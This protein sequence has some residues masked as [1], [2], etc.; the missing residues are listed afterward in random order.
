LTGPRGLNGTSGSSGSSGQDGTSGVDG[1]NGTS[2]V[3]GRKGE[4]GDKGDRG[5]PGL[6]G[7]AGAKGQDGTIGSNGQS[8]TSGTSGTSAPGIT[9]G[10][11]G[12]SGISGSSGSSGTSGTSGSS[13]SSGTS[14]TSSTPVKISGIHGAGVVAGGSIS[15]ALITN[16]GK[17]TGGSFLANNRLWIQPFI[18]AKTF[19]MAS[20]SIEVTATGTA[21]QLYIKV[22]DDLNGTPNNF[23]FG[24]GALTGSIGIKTYTT[25]YQFVAG[26]LYWL[27][28]NSNGSATMRAIGSAASYPLQSTAG[29]AVFAGATITQTATN[30]AY[31]G[32]SYT[33]QNLGTVE[34]T[35]VV[36][37]VP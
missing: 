19:T 16:A 31:P 14:G 4:K 2:G 17:S 18:P 21:G 12:T 35:M 15:A 5:F 37:S 9:S 3:N 34:F 32:G 27:G 28:V 8:G 25:S 24:S 36:T 1:Q 13:G 6:Q 33:L 7:P 23:L 30:N 22:Y 10:T 29:T 11:S 20:I 26:S